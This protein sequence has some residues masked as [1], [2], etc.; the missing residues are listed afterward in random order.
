MAAKLHVDWIK[1]DGWGLCA[2]LL[3][4]LI[5]LDEW[6]YPILRQ[7]IVERGRLDD[8]QRAADCCP[9]KALILEAAD[10]GRRRG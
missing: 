7:P 10:A 4:E 2:D 3:P 9:A 6:R 5:D 1:C 8:A